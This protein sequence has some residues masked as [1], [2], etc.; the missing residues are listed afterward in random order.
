[1]SFL[2]LMQ[3]HMEWVHK[4]QR[5]EEE[6][7]PGDTVGHGQADKR[8]RIPFIVVA[9]KLDLLDEE[10]NKS[11]EVKLCA[12][13]Q[14]RSVMGF[15]GGYYKGKE[16]K[17][18]YAAEN[19][20]FSAGEGGDRTEH[21]ASTADIHTDAATERGHSND[22]TAN[23]LTYPL[24][25]TLWCA[26]ASYLHALQLVEDQLAANRPMILLWCRRHGFPH[27]EVSALDGRG[28]DEAM[29]TLIALG[30][31]ELGAR[32]MAKR[33]RMD[34]RDGVDAE[35]QETMVS[36]QA[37]SECGTLAS[38]GTRPGTHN[39]EADNGI[40]QNET[41][42]ANSDASVSTD[43]SQHYFLYQPRQDETLD[44]FARYSPKDE[45]RCAPFKCWLSFFAHCRR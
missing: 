41:T 3:W 2:H 30:V 36:Q 38:L 37:P 17:Y 25:E 11:R 31:E 15:V 19:T 16:L 39:V 10:G 44:L 33:E 18:E 20:H 22:R 23:K 29:A 7:E 34:D 6:C 21:R 26:D 32:D 12:K 9:T 40:H 42:G 24:K 4:L 13:V 1:M 35:T 45:P 28:V 5:W 8:K 14:R 43:P 27:A